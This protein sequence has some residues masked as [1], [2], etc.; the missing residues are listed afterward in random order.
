M[1][2]II[3]III[4]YACQIY[5][6][7]Y[8]HSSKNNNIEIEKFGRYLE[9]V[10]CIANNTDPLLSSIC[11]DVNSRDNFDDD[12]LYGYANNIIP[13]C[14]DNKFNKSNPIYFELC[15][16]ARITSD[17]IVKRKD[18]ASTE[19]II[20]IVFG[21][22]GGVFIMCLVAYGIYSCRK[23]FS[24]KPNYTFRSHD[25]NVPNYTI[26]NQIQY[27]DL[28]RPDYNVQYNNLYNGYSLYNMPNNGSN[29]Y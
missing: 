23:E 2:T 21:C 4:M 29:F 25:S 20:G 7:I 14:D 13:N 17:L 24:D 9:E 11:N 1:K 8:A 26:Q 22:L 16:L 6:K 19:K 27:N 18:N 3:I 15:S 10:M 12:T 28:Y 5:G